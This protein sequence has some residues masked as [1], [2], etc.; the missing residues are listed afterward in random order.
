MLTGNDRTT[1]KGKKI[2]LCVLAFLLVV[3]GESGCTA[4][5]EYTI[6]LAVASSMQPVMSVL[7]ETYQKQSDTKI[8]LISASSG[9][10]TAQILN[11]AP[12]DLFISADQVYTD[13]L[14]SVGK[15]IGD[16]EDY[17][18]GQLVLW[19][20][21]SINGSNALIASS[22]QQIGVANPKTAPYGARAIAYL[23]EHAYYDQIKEK[24]VFGESV[25]QTSQFIERGAVQMGIV[26][27][28][29]ASLPALKNKG[30]WIPLD[31]PPVLHTITLLPH[32]EP[33]NHWVQPFYT[34]LYSKE[35]KNVL[36]QYGFKMVNKKTK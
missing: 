3:L 24:L 8:D 7:I 17:V 21:D 18:Y 13:R 20:K 30:N 33:Y 32:G 27:A 28:S 26:S 1:L 16:A 23:K 11:G 6:K 15:I 25:S 36:K 22:V 2:I 4:N 19:A 35:A 12:Y 9:K 31:A 5:R 29:I 10:L 14:K 34:F